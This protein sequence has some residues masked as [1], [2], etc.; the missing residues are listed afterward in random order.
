MTERDPP[1]SAAPPP[2]FAPTPWTWRI[3]IGAV[4]ALIASAAYLM[5]GVIGPR[6]QAVAGLFFFFG[7]VAACSSNLRAPRPHRAK[8]RQR[9]HVH[10]RL[11]SAAADFVRFGLLHRTLSLRRLAAHRA[12]DGSRHGAF[13]GHQRRRNI[14]GRSEEHTSELQSRFGISYAVFCLK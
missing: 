11:Q 12:P 3:S 1:A 10:I 5:Q 13:D 9:I 8:S 2:S 7:L 6:G 4:I 14:I